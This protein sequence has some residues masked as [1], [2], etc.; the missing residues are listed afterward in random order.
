MW[1]SLYKNTGVPHSCSLIFNSKKV[2]Y[3]SAQGLTYSEVCLFLH[4]TWCNMYDVAHHKGN[5]IEKK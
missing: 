5:T 2:K 4:V 1:L 3:L